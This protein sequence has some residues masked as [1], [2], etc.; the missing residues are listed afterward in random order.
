V[1]A[2]NTSEILPLIAQGV[3]E[4][5]QITL[6]IDPVALRANTTNASTPF[7]DG[8]K[9]FVC[10]SCVRDDDCTCRPCGSLRIHADPRPCRSKSPERC[11]P[12]LEGYCPIGFLGLIRCCVDKGARGRDCSAVYGGRDCCPGL[13]CNSATLQTGFLSIFAGIFSLIG[14]DIP[15]GNCDSINHV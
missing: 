11:G 13:S 2:W 4:T 10:Y 6:I 8:T 7:S 15:T 3:P 1:E 5:P 14:I 12:C 9:K